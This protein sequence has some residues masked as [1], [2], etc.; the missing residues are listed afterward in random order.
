MFETIRKQF[1]YR[2]KYVFTIHLHHISPW[3]MDDKSA[4][5]TWKRGNRQNRRGE[6][7]VKS[8]KKQHPNDDKTPILNIDENF[9]FEVTLFS[10][11][12]T[13][14]NSSEGLLGG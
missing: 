10:V 6:T 7:K 5:I 12:H 8:P 1:E 11:S 14:A 13:F 3:F 4:V 2:S 9:D